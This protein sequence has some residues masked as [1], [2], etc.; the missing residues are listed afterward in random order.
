MWFGIVSN[1]I[2]DPRGKRKSPSISE[3]CM[4]FTFKAKKYMPLRTPMVSQITWRVLDN[5]CAD[6]IELTCSPSSEPFL[7][8]MNF[9]LNI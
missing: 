1:L 8:L 6:I 3:L 2:A 5:S 4:K 7:S 9:R